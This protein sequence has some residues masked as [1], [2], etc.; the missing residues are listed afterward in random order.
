MA[1]SRISIAKSD[2]V[3]LF[4]EY[5]EKVFTLSRLQSLFQ[6][7]RR[8]WRLAQSMSCLQFI[9]YLTQNSRLNKFK[10]DFA[11]R[12]MI[13]YVWGEVSLYTILLALKRG[14]YFSHY[15]AV[16]FHE[17]TEQL[18]RTIYI[19]VEQRAKPRPKGSLVQS[20]IDA[21]FKRPTRLSG[22]IAEHGDKRLCLL[23]G[24]FTGELGVVEMD[25]PDGSTVHATD[26]ERTLIDIAVR[27]EYSGGPFEVLR[28]YRAANTKG[29]IAINRLAS[30]LKKLNYIYPYHQIVGFYLD[31]CGAYDKSQIAL[32]SDRFQRQYDFYL[33]H[34]M[35]DCDYSHEW[36]LHFPKG[37]G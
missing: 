7:N 25:G 34:Q 37:L 20:R 18:P 2:I 14:S 27:P 36:K 3:N 29:E 12:P 31:R 35:K 15:T 28:A 24:M 1:K 21:A 5:P 22:N 13:L 23:N 32:F 26:V 19:N 4:D 16:Y 33:M 30:T 6:A 8:F 9:D 10:F 11:Y 17:M